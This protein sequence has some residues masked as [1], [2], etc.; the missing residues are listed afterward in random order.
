MSSSFKEL[1][2]QLKERVHRVDKILGEIK[3]SS[4]FDTMPLNNAVSNLRLQF[5]KVIQLYDEHKKQ[6]DS[7]LIKAK[8]EFDT[9]ASQT[10][11]ELRNIDTSLKELIQEKKPEKV[12]EKVIE[13]KPKND[14][15]I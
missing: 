15:G 2:T 14:S 1:K 8:Q 12:P 13:K 9:S 4:E 10:S 3:K 6:I 7:K 5:E 11:E